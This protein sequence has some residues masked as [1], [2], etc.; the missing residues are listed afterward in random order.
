[1]SSAVIGS[2]LTIT[3]TCWAPAAVAKIE[4]PATRIMAVTS[5]RQV[6]KLSNIIASSASSPMGAGTLPLLVR[7][8][9]PPV[10]PL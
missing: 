3:T 2:P 1:M 4:A 5:L 6:V 9:P 8:D 7:R 10:Q